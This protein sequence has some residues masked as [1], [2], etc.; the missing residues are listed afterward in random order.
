MPWLYNVQRGLNWKEEIVKGLKAPTYSSLS[1]NLFLMMK[2]GQIRTPDWKF[3]V[4][5]SIFQIYSKDNIPKLYKIVKLI[6]QIIQIINCS[7]NR[8]KILCI[9]LTSVIS[10]VNCIEGSLQPTRQSRSAIKFKTDNSLANYFCTEIT[11]P[12]IIRWITR[13]WVDCLI[14]YL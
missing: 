5:S 7:D 1:I 11:L 6:V 13:N 14:S 2:T 3:E 8:F 4:E 10:I 9:I 12:L